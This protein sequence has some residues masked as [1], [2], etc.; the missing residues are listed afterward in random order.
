VTIYVSADS[1]LVA[2]SYTRHE[3]YISRDSNAYNSRISDCNH[4]VPHSFQSN[5][6][7][8]CFSELGL[9]TQNLSTT[10][11]GSRRRARSFHETEGVAAQ[12]EGL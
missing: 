2:V 12:S 5:L 7:Y 9:H 3:H 1:V 10:E 8:R 4:H 11:N 6:D